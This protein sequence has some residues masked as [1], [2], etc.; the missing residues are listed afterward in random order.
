MPPRLIFVERPHGRACEDACRR[1]LPGPDPLSAL[2]ALRLLPVAI[3]LAVLAA[4]FY[5]AWAWVPFGITI[6]LLPLLFVRAPWAARVLQAA[7]VVGALEWLR[8]AAALVAL[9]QSMGLPY[10]RLAI[11]LGAVAI[12]TGLAALI[13]RLRKVRARFGIRTGDLPPTPPA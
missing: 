11:I 10:T 12:A 6:G 9:R 4:H 5:R 1:P 8:T 7:L 2:N 13:F 3:A